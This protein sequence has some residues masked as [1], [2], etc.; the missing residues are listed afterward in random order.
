[1]NQVAGGRLGNINPLLYGMATAAPAAFHVHHHREQ[2]GHVH[3]TTASTR[4]RGTGNLYGYA[5]TTGYDCASRP[6]GP[7][8]VY[9]F[10]WS[11]LASDAPTTTSL[12]AVPTS[13]TE[14]G[15]VTLTATVDVTATNADPL[16]G[17]VTFAFQSYLANGSLDLSWTLGTAAISGGTT[18]SRDGVS[19][20]PDPAGSRREWDAGRRRR[21]DVHGGDS[22]HLASTS[23]KV[24]ITFSSVGF[25]ITPSA[26]SVAAGA[27]LTRLHGDGG[28]RLSPLVHLRRLDLRRERQQLFVT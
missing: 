5:A 19:V 13:P 10:F 11:A 14:T 16:G 6:P 8:D 21:C 28:R 26:T 7:M 2:R 3:R 9:N 17:L 1:M 23:S 20:G 25:C 27:T 15:E 24:R 12:G 18:S 22:H 4:A